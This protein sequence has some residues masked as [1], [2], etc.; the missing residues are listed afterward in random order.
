MSKVVH[1]KPKPKITRVRTGCWTCKRRRKC[2]EAKPTC[3]NC[4]EKG[5]VCEGYGVRLSFDVDDS[6]HSSS[7]IN[8]KGEAIYGFRGRPR[9][10][11]SLSKRSQPENQTS[12]TKTA[13]F[14]FMVNTD[15]K[16]YSHSPVSQ[17]SELLQ[18][19]SVQSPPRQISLQTPTVVIPRL[20]QPTQTVN[21]LLYHLPP[22]QDITP[23]LDIPEST[24]P[25]FPKLSTRHGSDSAVTRDH[26]PLDDSIKTSAFLKDFRIFEDMFPSLI[27]NSQAANSDVPSFINSLSRGISFVAPSFNKPA[28]ELQQ[29]S[30]NVTMSANYETTEENLIL[31]HFFN[32]LLPLTDA[33]P[34]TPWPQLILKYCDF[35][36]AKSCFISLACIHLY[37]TQ[38]ASEFYKTGMDHI[39]ATMEYLIN[40]LKDLYENENGLSLDGSDDRALD[41][42]KLVIHLKEQRSTEENRTNFM[43]ILILIH[44][45]LLFS[46]L[47][48]GR[49]ALGRTFFELANAIVSDPEFKGYLNGIEGSSTLVG[50][51]AW[52]DIISAMVSPDCRLPD[53]DDIWLGSKD[54]VFSTSKLMGCPPEIFKIMKQFCILRKEFKDKNQVL[55]EDIMS[56]FKMIKH[57]LLD[58]REY[59]D[60]ED[61]N[62]GYPERLKCTQCWTLALLLNLYQLV[63]P[64]ETTLINEF[65]NEFINVYSSLSSLSPIISQMVWPVFTVSCSAT[66]E[67]Q[68]QSCEKYLIALYQ[69]TK[70]GTVSSVIKL[71]KKCWTTGVS[72]D[73]ILSGEEWFASGIDFLVI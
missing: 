11:E 40:Y 69:N 35:E 62:F 36:V 19:P 14:K 48:S 21:S 20:A 63:K 61:Q 58:Y 42:K 39:T 68:R 45:H 15:L 29:P 54:S 70:S 22:L 51:I 50:N 4:L 46:I 53:S 56:R 26:T 27:S 23:K 73:E 2:D 9:L 52:F 6:R 33:H 55:D 25:V 34:S 7:K 5:K 67:K 18:I 66:L 3:N 71:T 72:I 37:E 57:R 43:V 44:V 49:T 17:S 8:K 24:D 59:V 10:N 13:E 64:K 38:G 16:K 32:T 60:Y 28:H 12:A 31:K 1:D 65:I 30:M 41:V 47:E